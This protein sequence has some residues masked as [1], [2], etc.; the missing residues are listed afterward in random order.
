MRCTS[1]LTTVITIIMVVLLAPPIVA[2]RQATTGESAI[3]HTTDAHPVQ[4]LHTIAIATGT[5][6]QRLAPLRLAAQLPP[7]ERHLQRLLDQDE[8]DMNNHT[9]MFPCV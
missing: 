2:G 3:Q 7:P 8:R 5:P 1:S 9:A 6:L 4:D